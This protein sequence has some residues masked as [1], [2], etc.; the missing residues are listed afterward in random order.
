MIFEIITVSI[1]ELILI[2]F[3]VTVSIVQIDTVDEPRTRTRGDIK[4]MINAIQLPPRV[5][6]YG[7]QKG[8]GTTMPT[9]KKKNL[10][11]G[12]PEREEEQNRTRKMRKC[13]TKAPYPK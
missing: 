2:S 4:K 13:K 5:R 6:K 7:K 11:K 8:F 12:A 9:Q 10:R 3:V 1:Y